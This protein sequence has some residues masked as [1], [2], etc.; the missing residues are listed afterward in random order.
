MEEESSSTDE[1][2]IEPSMYGE[3]SVCGRRRD[4]EDAVSVRPEFPPD[5]HFFGVFDGHGCSHVSAYIS[6]LQINLSF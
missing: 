1:E 2:E 4:M 3:T 5:H 6:R